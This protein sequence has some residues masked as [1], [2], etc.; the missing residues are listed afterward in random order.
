MN[1]IEIF[2]S[3]SMWIIL[4]IIFPS[5]KHTDIYTDESKVGYRYLCLCPWSNWKLRAM[6]K[7]Q[8]EMFWSLNHNPP[9]KTSWK[10]FLHI[11]W[12]K[13]DITVYPVVAGDDIRQFVKVFCCC[14]LVALLPWTSFSHTCWMCYLYTGN[15][16]MD[17]WPNFQKAQQGRAFCH[18]RRW[19]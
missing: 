5:L 12:D 13:Y 19:V 17:M 10:S 9:P 1:R 3:S 11:Y 8:L 18:P 4:S 7:D 6:L 14:S 15:S 16:I 2:Y